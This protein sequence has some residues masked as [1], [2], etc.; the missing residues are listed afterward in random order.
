MT[1][2]TPSGIPVLHRDE[3]TVILDKPAGVPVELP[4]NARGRSVLAEL[5]E[6]HAEARLPHRLDA[7][8]SGVLVVALNAKSAAYHSAQVAERAW[9]KLY[10]ATVAAPLQQVEQLVGA[11]KSYLSRKGKRAESVRAGGKPAFL[12][13][14]AVESAGAGAST[15]LVRLRTGRYHQIRVMMAER[16]APLVGDA[17]YGGPAGELRLTHAALHASLGLNIDP[18]W[19]VSQSR[20]Y[21]A[22]GAIECALRAWVDKPPSD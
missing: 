17:L 4:A 14:L 9:T 18:R 15:V 2:P 12:D 8:T 22:G 10:T 5:K 13:V 7:V 3:G 20:G 16:G 19:F 6:T 21:E 1:V 11:H